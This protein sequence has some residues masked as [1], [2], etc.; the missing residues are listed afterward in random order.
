MGEKTIKLLKLFWKGDEVYDFLR[1]AR[2]F[3]KK[4]G[5]QR[6]RTGDKDREKTVLVSLKFITKT[7]IGQF[8]LFRLCNRR[9]RR[10]YF[11]IS[12]SPE[13]KKEKKNKH[14]VLFTILRTLNN[15]K[16]VRLINTG[17]CN[18]LSLYYFIC[19]KRLSSFKN[20][21]RWTGGVLE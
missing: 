19:N 5:L 12:A 11:L 8:V 7:L 13:K 9:P 2:R 18:C 21:K 20:E 16:C 3:P 6:Q 15:F 17:K 4:W 10:E 1:S 14:V